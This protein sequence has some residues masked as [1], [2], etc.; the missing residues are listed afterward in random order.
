MD[1][2]LYAAFEPGY[3]LL[4]TLPEHFMTRLPDERLVI[5]DRRRRKLTLCRNNSWAMIAEE[6][7]QLE[8]PAL[9]LADPYTKLWTTF[10]HSIA[11]QSRNN[12]SLQRS[13]MPKKRW[14]YLPEMQ[15]EK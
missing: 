14:D 9:I 7:L 11:V 1:G 10:S 6:G 4:E 2:L 13:R 15:C 8:L 5:Q 3:D 12:P